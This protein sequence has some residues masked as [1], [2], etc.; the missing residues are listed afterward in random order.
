MSERF[1]V[2]VSRVLQSL[3]SCVYGSKSSGFGLVPEEISICSLTFS[4]TP[5]FCNEAILLKFVLKLCSHRGLTQTGVRSYLRCFV[6]VYLTLRTHTRL[7]R[8]RSRITIHTHSQS[9]S[10]FIENIRYLY[11]TFWNIPTCNIVGFGIF[12]RCQI[13]ERKLSREK[14]KRKHQGKI[15]DRTKEKIDMVNIYIKKETKER[16]KTNT[17]GKYLYSLSLMACLRLCHNNWLA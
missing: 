3:L 17:Q 7:P 5:H 13:D 15:P 8:L 6:Y 14:P 1:S 4:I 16:K 11:T 2:G 10:F 9:H 12:L